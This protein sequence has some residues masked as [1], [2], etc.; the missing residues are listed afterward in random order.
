MSED[1]RKMIDKVKN[2]KQFVNENINYQYSTTDKLVKYQKYLLHEGLWRIPY[3]KL[4][5]LI[6]IRDIEKIRKNY[7]EYPEEEKILDVIDKLK[8]NIP[9]EPIVLD[10]NYV[11]VDG[12]HRFEAAK[13]LHIKEL[14]VIFLN[15]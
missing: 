2:F 5:D 6:Y 9:L 1:I 13:E 8:N 14:P 12:H 7:G 10:S 11:I 15:N 3:D 4:S